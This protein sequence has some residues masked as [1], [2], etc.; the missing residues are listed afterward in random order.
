MLK[1]F[2]MKNFVDS[3]KKANKNNKTR[4]AHAYVSNIQGEVREKRHKSV[5]KA[6]KRIIIH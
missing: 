5:R 3:N 2:D 1:K 6:N 4:M